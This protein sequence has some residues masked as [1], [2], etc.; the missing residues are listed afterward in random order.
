[1]KNCAFQ[2]ATGDGTIVADT[3]LITK[4]DAEEMWKNHIAKF[5]RH[6]EEGRDPEMALWIDMK[7]DTDYH[8]A[9]KHWCGSDFIV[10]GGVLFLAQAVA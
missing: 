1:M 8:T 9:E 6:V 7:D 3:D 10:R 4:D 5:K 2:Y